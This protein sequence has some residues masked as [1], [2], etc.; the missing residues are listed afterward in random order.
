MTPRERLLALRDEENAAFV[1]KLVPD[2]PPESILGVRAP[3]LK[4]LARE[5]AGTDEAAA[6]LSELPHALFDENML[7]GFLLA[8][9]KDYGACLTAVERFLPFVDNWAV[10]DSL[11]P[12][13]FARHRE[14]LL[15]E[16]PRWLASERTYTQR[17]GLGMLMTHYL[18]GDFFQACLDWAAA[19][20][21][22]EYYVRMMVAW[23]FA[24]ALAK[25][26]EEALPY[27][28]GRRLDAWT[29]NKAIRKAIESCRVTDEHKAVL[30]TL[31]IK[32]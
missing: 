32:K 18:D 9:M 16:I 8:Q 21:S 1:A 27:L 5:L 4:Q 14:E 11:R 20:R 17:F 2:V 24:T 19:C 31:V 28:T 22:E 10:C 15:E 23:F 12:R 6:F 25:R 29:H 13:C 3:A 30:R 7:H 26:Y